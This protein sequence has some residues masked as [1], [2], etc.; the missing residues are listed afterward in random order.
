VW[1]IRVRISIWWRVRVKGEGEAKDLGDE[2]SDH[3]RFH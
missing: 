3:R 1:G 2:D